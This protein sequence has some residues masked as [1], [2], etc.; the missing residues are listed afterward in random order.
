MNP[1]YGAIGGSMASRAYGS[2]GGAGIDPAMS[3]AT[4]PSHTT[5]A[6]AGSVEVRDSICP[7]VTPT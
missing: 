7:C 2:T 3:P 4:F 5:W 1:P 6:Q